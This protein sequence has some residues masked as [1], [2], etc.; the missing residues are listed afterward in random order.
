MCADLW[1]SCFV[2]HRVPI[3]LRWLLDFY[4]P[5]ELTGTLVSSFVAFFRQHGWNHLF[6]TLGL[7]RTKMTS[8]ISWHALILC[9]AVRVFPP[10]RW[11]VCR[12]CPPLSSVHFFLAFHSSPLSLTSML[13][14]TEIL[15]LLVCTQD[16]SQ[17]QGRKVKDRGEGE[18]KEGRA[19][20]IQVPSGGRKDTQRHGLT[21]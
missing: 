17:W 6:T 7:L 3:I 20:T 13:S 10:S 9:S 12:S 21:L 1:W 15:W 5:F 19:R 16:R 18:G 2:T 8:K 14:A 11:Y 4:K